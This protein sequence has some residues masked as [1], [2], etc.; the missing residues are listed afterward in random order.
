[1]AGPLS[2]FPRGHSGGQPGWPRLT[3]QAPHVDAPDAMT[4]QQ[5]FQEIAAILARG[6]L[7]H[8]RMHAS[9][10]TSRIPVESG[11]ECLEVSGDSRLSVP[12]G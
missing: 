6:V 11:G 12:T 2:S 9:A 5:R 3:F 7:R 8:R 4:P 1:M 10:P